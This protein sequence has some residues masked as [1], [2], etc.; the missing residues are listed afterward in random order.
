MYV[1]IPIQPTYIHTQHIQIHSDYRAAFQ[2]FIHLLHRPSPSR[3]AHPTNLNV[4]QDNVHIQTHTRPPVLAP[5]IHLT[6]HSSP[7]H[8]LAGFSVC[9]AYMAHPP[10]PHV[11][12]CSVLLPALRRLS[13]PS[14]TIA[15]R[16]RSARND[17]LKRPMGSFSFVVNNPSLSV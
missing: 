16:K 13:R 8:T 15:G 1:P 12:L 4:S 3:Q 6:T 11:M 10:L 14:A 7:F 17:F 2:T 5:N 9:I